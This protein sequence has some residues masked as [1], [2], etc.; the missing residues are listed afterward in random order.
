MERL[1]KRTEQLAMISAHAQQTSGVNSSNRYTFMFQFTRNHEKTFDFAWA[2]WFS[3]SKCM[4]AM[5][6]I[7]ASKDA[8]LHIHRGYMQK[9]AFELVKT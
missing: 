3:T 1:S 8:M 6:W 9:L 4:H 2:T 7:C 5:L